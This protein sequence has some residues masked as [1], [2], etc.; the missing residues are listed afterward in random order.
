[1]GLNITV[2]V[3]RVYLNNWSSSVENTESE[4]AEKVLGI[5]LLL[6]RYSGQVV[7]NTASLNFAHP[8]DEKDFLTSDLRDISIFSHIYLTYHK[9]ILFKLKQV[10]QISLN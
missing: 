5:C 1:M 3:I 9:L 2:Y 4:Y 6:F 10:C 7:E 8:Q